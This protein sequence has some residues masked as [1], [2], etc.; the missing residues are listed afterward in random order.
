KVI[1]ETVC[2]KNESN[3]NPFEDIEDLRNYWKE[4]NNTTIKWKAPDGLFW[5]CGKRAYNELKKNCRGTYTIGIIQPVFFLLPK[6]KGK[7][8]GQPL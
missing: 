1:N 2:W 7:L 8:L 5:I 3:A 6:Q 4:P